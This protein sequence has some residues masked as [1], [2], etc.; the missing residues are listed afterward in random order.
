MMTDFEGKIK[1][2]KKECLGRCNQQLHKRVQGNYIIE[3]GGCFYDF[4]S[5]AHFCGE[6]TD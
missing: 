1:Q 3:V 6:K 2:L 4:Q 5:L